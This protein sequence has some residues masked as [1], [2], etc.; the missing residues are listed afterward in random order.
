MDAGFVTSKKQ[1]TTTIV[2][3][4]LSRWQ[5]RF[6]SSTVIACNQLNFNRIFLVISRILADF[7]SLSDNSANPNISQFFFQP[8]VFFRL[9][10]G[11]LG[12]LVADEQTD[13]LRT[14]RFWP[15]RGI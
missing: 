11:G 9:Q 13:I 8:S 1:T 10:I 2:G 12:L 7:F 4:H 5:F 3:L 14:L 6:N 15:S